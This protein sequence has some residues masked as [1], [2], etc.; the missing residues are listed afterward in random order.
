MEKKIVIG[1]LTAI[2]AVAILASTIFA[3]VPHDFEEADLKDS[4]LQYYD[5]KDKNLEKVKLPD[6]LSEISGLATDAVGRLFGHNDEN[7]AVYQVDPKTG[8]IIKSFQI[9]STPILDDFEGIA[10][11]G[12]QFF[13]VN[14]SGMLYQFEEG[15]DG[16]TVEPVKRQT[17][18]GWKNDVEGLCYDPTTNTL[19]LACK[20]DPGPGLKKVRAIYSFDLS[21]MKLVETPRFTFDIK[22][23]EKRSKEDLFMPS[24]IEY[25]SE[26]GTFFL[27][28]G[29]GMTVVEFDAEGELL[30]WVALDNNL[31]AQPE[32]I[33][34]LPDGSMVISDEQDGKRGSFTVY[35]RKAKGE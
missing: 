30:G 1:S 8:D 3:P 33:A 22:D 27:L 5:F 13:L 31:H 4:A 2:V 20:E 21:T 12:D 26:T 29:R 23:M 11:V 24:A 7:G 17:P 10:I 14:S 16:G 35:P 9:G 28:S 34:F 25:N 19:L 15:E 6:E 18:L 32:G